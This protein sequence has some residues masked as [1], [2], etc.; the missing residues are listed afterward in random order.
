MG[1]KGMQRHKTLQEVLLESQAMTEEQLQEAEAEAASSNKPLQQIILDRKVMAKAQLL[2]VLTEGWQVEVAD[3]E[4][5]DI[6]ADLVKLIPEKLAR[7][8]TAV[9]IAKSENILA[10]AMANPCDLDIMED[11]K[12]RTGLDIKPYLALPHEIFATLDAAYGKGGAPLIKAIME[13]ERPQIEEWALPKDAGLEMVKEQKS[14][15]AKVDASAPEIEKLVNAIILNALAL[16]A[17]D[18]HIEPVEDPAGNNS[19]ILLRYRVDGVLIPG[20]KIPWAYR[21]ALA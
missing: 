8:Y 3:I 5:M 18:I 13:E 6:S 12:L 7:R 10:F 19:R 21:H 16:K 20:F 9:P 4:Q 1:V 17:S 2:K 11:L 14:D 15:I